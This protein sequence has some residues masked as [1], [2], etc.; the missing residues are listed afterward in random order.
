MSSIHIIYKTGKTTVPVIASTIMMEV[1]KK[2]CQYFKIDDSR[3]QLMY[4]S[5]YVNLSLPF[6]L[7]GIPNLSRVTIMEKKGASISTVKIAI[8]MDDGKRF[9]SNFKTSSTLWD[10]LLTF[11]TE[12]NLSLTKRFNDIN[13]YIE[14]V[15]TILNREISTIESLQ[16]SSLA[17]INVN[18]AS[19]IKLTFK[20]TD[21]TNEE[22]LPIIV[23]YQSPSTPTES[24][25]TTTTTTTTTSNNTTKEESPK[26]TNSPTI[27]ESSTKSQNSSGSQQSP[28]IISPPTQQSTSSEVSTPTMDI[29]SPLVKNVEKSPI[30]DLGLNPSSN[31]P[32][33]DKTYNNETTSTNTPTT[34]TTTTTSNNDVQ[35]STTT[36]PP[37]KITTMDH[38]DREL[39]VYIPSNNQ[40]DPKSIRHNEKMTEEDIKRLVEAN[41]RI[42]KEKEEFDS[43]LRTKAMR[44]REAYKK[45]KNFSTSIIR[46]VFPGGQKILEMKF[47]IREKISNLLKYINEYI[48]AEPNDSVY[49]YTTPPNKT[50]DLNTTFLK[51]GLF[52]RAKIFLGISPGTTLKFSELV[53]ELIEESNNKNNS[54]NNNTTTTST[55]SQEELDKQEEEQERIEEQMKIE[56][57]KQLKLE[58]E[59]EKERQRALRS[60]FNNEKEGD[61]QKRPV[62]KW[63]TAGKK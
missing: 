52:P 30:S 34:T 58:D 59:Q 63:F 50:L 44:E 6:R 14:P 53:N 9:Q 49:L 4:G 1:L 33:P 21:R 39:L 7:S 2:A 47:L 24:P 31:I 62:P 36:P 55:I 43:V 15:V 28:K 11:E 41:K 26:T 35:V 37:P 5:A 19:L 46:I 16:K 17:S 3:F 13:Q 51:E 42:K 54:N 29:D 25:T 32:L 12:Q 61:A 23:S 18:E 8:Q 20:Q 10:I 38:K 60:M 40:V 57:E 48:L 56:E 45:L 22:V 27:S